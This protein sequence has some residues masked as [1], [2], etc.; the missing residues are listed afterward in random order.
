[1]GYVFG[2]MFVMYDM[3]LST[4]FWLR[5]G[6]SQVLIGLGAFQLMRFLA[7]TR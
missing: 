2:V 5:F 4:P 3:L 7:L 1:M 6:L